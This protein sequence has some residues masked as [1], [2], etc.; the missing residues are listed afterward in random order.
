LRIERLMLE[1]VRNQFIVEFADQYVAAGWE[2]LYLVANAW[3]GAEVEDTGIN[4]T[5]IHTRPSLL[6]RIRQEIDRIEDEGRKPLVINETTTAPDK[7]HE[8]FVIVPRAVTALSPMCCPHCGKQVFATWDKVNELRV[9]CYTRSHPRWRQ[10]LH[11]TIRPPKGQGRGKYAHQRR[12]SDHHKQP[13][14]AEQEHLTRQLLDE[15]HTHAQIGARMGRTSGS[16]SLFL[17]RGGMEGTRKRQQR[18]QAIASL[19]EQMEALMLQQ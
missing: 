5:V 17:H 2:V 13:W 8:N 10:P 9:A 4:A 11:P 15:G 14:T 1:P 16:V 12:S 19:D 6:A 7:V 3:R 18:R